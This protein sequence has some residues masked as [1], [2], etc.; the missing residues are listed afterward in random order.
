MN[1][2]SRGTTLRFSVAAAAV[3]VA[4]SGCSAVLSTHP[5]GERPQA[6]DPADWDGTWLAEDGALTFKVVDPA[7]GK[8]VVGWIEDSEG[9]LGLES[10]EALLLSSN[11]RLFVNIR[12]DA[13]EDGKPPTPRYLFAL[14]RREGA[15]LVLWTPRVEPF[16]TLVDNGT[17]PG[18]AEGDEIVLGPMSPEQL[19]LVTSGRAAELFAWDEPVVFRRLIPSPD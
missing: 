2:E 6:V 5:V 13:E 1:N 19:A 12:D 15:E 3:A 4:I 16:R 8:L 11:D 10:L 9:E 17:L 14:A 18:Q 7:A